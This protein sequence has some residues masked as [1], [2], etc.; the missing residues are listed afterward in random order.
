MGPDVGDLQGLP[1]RHERAVS[2]NVVFGSR[3]GRTYDTD[4]QHVRVHDR[5]ADELRVL[6]LKFLRRRVSDAVLREYEPGYKPDENEVLYLPANDQAI[7]GVLS[8]LYNLSDMAVF[9]EDA[10]FIRR[11]KFHA[12]IDGGASNS[13][14]ALFRAFAPSREL[15]RRFL[16]T[17]ASGAYN[18]FRERIFALD[19][20]VD[21]ALAGDWIFIFNPQAFEKIFD[22]VERLEAQALGALDDAVQHVPIA[23]LDEMKDAC[24]RDTAMLRKALAISGRPYIERLTVARVIEHARRYGRSLSTVVVDGAEQLVFDGHPAHRWTL[25]KILDDDYLHSEMSDERYEA[26]SKMAIG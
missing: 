8:D 23:N 9:A 22:Y 17:L 12:L 18:R 3:A 2:V 19:G 11:L 21:C 16:V 26:N 13:R 5:V 7:Q 14:L 4:V 15:S 20:K 6:P 10:D 24:R 1:Q 25:L